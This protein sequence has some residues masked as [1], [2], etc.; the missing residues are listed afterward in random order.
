MKCSQP[1]LKPAQHDQSN[2]MANREIPVSLSLC[3]GEILQRVYL[4]HHEPPTEALF[5]VSHLNPRE[6]ACIFV[7]SNFLTFVN[8]SR[9]ILVGKQTLSVL[10]DRYTTKLPSDSQAQAMRLRYQ[11]PPQSRTHNRKK[12]CT[13]RYKAAQTTRALVRTNNIGKASTPK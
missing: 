7:I 11:P 12:I 10:E 8:K 4:T 13:H 9:A 3:G 1:I 5:N 2:A 6:P